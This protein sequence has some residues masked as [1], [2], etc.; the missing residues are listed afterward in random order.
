M[1]QKVIFISCMLLST[2]HLCPN[3]AAIIGSIPDGHI[4]KMLHRNL[5]YADIIVLH[6][7]RIIVLNTLQPATVETINTF[8]ELCS[9]K[10]EGIMG[11]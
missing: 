8:L 3:Q 10:H 2:L 9:I 6:L 4:S 11:Y 1:W 7:G 5:S